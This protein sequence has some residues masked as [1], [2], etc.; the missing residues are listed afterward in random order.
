MK[1]T[2]PRRHIE[3]N[4]NELDRIIDRS[5]Q[6]PLSAAESQKL[7]TALHTMAN[8][9]MRKRSTEKTS[10]VLDKPAAVERAAEESDAGAVA[11]TGHGRNAAAD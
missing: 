9:L 11:S 10:A 1:K 6:A 5:T 3:V 4:L 7:R 8:G 2:K